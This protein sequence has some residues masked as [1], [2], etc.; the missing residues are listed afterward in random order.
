VEALRAAARDGVDVRLL[1]PGTSD[2]PLT[3]AFSRTGYRPLLEGGVRVF[4]WNG[5]MLHAKT[6]VADTRWSRVGSSNLNLSS[7]LA[8][9]ELDL[10]IHDQRFAG[11]MEQ[12]YLQ[13]LA[14]ATEIVLARHN[15]IRPL[16]VQRPHHSMRMRGSASRAAASAM[17]IGN[18]VSAALTDRRVL[19]ASEAGITAKF[20]LALAG[21]TVLALLFPR[22]IAIPFALITAWVGVALLVRAWRLR[23][24]AAA[25]EDGVARERP[26]R[27][28]AGA[29]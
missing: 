13:D 17:R 12:M 20:G 21:L 6:A 19:G 18:T 27:P 26:Q 14:N 28:G 24:H 3:Q 16:G 11:Q 4:E 8:N 10:A 9:Y 22:T 29:P 2:L 23:R 25:A 1:V 15:R 5:S 7:W